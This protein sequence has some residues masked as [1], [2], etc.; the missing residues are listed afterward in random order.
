MEK[1]TYADRRLN[2]IAAVRRRRKKVRQMALEYKGN[3]CS[4]CGYDR[5]AEALEFHHLDSSEKDFGISDRGYTRSW[6]KI[7]EELDKCVLICANCH[8]EL[9]SNTQH[10]WETMNEKSGEIREAA[11]R[12]GGGNPERSLAKRNTVARNVQRLGFEERYQ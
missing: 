4:R 10:S 12:N 11:A 7:R 5:C 6:R 1:R 3:R 2:I 9:H 8:R